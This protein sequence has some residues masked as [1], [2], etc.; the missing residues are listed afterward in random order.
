MVLDVQDVRQPKFSSESVLSPF[1]D[2]RLLVGGHAFR[3]MG[4][5]RA[6][7]ALSTNSSFAQTAGFA[8]LSATTAL[9]V[10]IGPYWPSVVFRHAALR[11]PES[12]HHF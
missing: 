1:S 12:G 11:L 8:K 3:K 5:L 9:R 6:F 2:V 4:G 7:A 10:V